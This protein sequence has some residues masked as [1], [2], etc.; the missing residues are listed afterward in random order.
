MAYR[1]QVV[2]LVQRDCVDD[3]LV[4]VGGPIIVDAEC[5][6]EA[7]VKAASIR[8]TQRHDQRSTYHWWLVSQM[9]GQESSSLSPYR[10]AAERVQ[11]V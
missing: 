7:R 2:R 4:M 11:V 8:M 5:L 3:R 1:M 6:A 10:W 9:N